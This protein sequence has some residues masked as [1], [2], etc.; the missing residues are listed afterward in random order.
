MGK[1]PKCNLNGNRRCGFMKRKSY[2][3]VDRT[4][5]SFK[6][7]NKE[8]V[9]YLSNLKR[10]TS[11]YTIR[12]KLHKRFVSMFKLQVLKIKIILNCSR[13]SSVCKIPIAYGVKILIHRCFLTSFEFPASKKKITIP[14]N[15]INDPNKIL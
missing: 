14:I 6:E 1:L 10:E 9:R 13:V 5:F 3:K 11:L 4:S 8:K 15:L 7:R 12:W 2:Y